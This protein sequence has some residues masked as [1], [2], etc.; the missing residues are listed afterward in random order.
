[1]KPEKA[2]SL[3]QR[4]IVGE[5]YDEKGY[6][7][8]LGYEALDAIDR[9]KCPTLVQRPHGEWIPCSERLPTA[10]DG[11]RVVVH[12]CFEK[13]ACDYV[14]VPWQTVK[15]EY[16]VGHIDAWFAIPKYEKRGERE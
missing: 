15:F 6:L 11:E 13:P 2:I 4:G 14:F 5:I 12:I 9:S 8:A 3:L 7:T 10:E 1:M 16:Q